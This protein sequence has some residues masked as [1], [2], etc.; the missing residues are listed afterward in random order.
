MLNRT[1]SLPHWKHIVSLIRTFPTSELALVPWCL[2]MRGSRAIVVR[3]TPPPPEG[4]PKLQAWTYIKNSG[5]ETQQLSKTETWELKT[6][7]QTQY[8]H[9]S[10]P[11]KQIR[12]VHPTMPTHVILN[13][14]TGTWC[15]CLA[16]NMH[17]R[18]SPKHTH[19]VEYGYVARWQTCNWR[20][21]FMK[22]IIGNL[23]IKTSNHLKGTARNKT[24]P[25][26][27]QWYLAN[28]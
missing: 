3:R 13:D 6:S 12:F 17:I 22:E 9:P 1:I 18:F 26:P 21:A 16:Q 10:C 11:I 2:D 7:G 20:T 24:E 25:N 8:F 5:S 23:W 19:L 28:T 4:C 27:G 15:A 14:P